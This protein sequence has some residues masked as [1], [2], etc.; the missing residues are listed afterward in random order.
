MQ[1]SSPGTTALPATSSRYAK[2]VSLS[3][4]VRFDI[5]RDVFR[6]RGF[7]FET[8]FLPDSMSGAGALLFLTPAERRYLSQVQGR[9]YANMF[10]LVERFI[11]A[12]MLDVS[13]AHWLGDQTALEA[14]V[15][16]TDEELK[17]QE[18]FR[19]LELLAA[20]GMPDGYR[21]VPEANA[22]ASVVL[23]KSTWAVLALICHIEVFVL[24]HYRQSIAPD[25]ELSPL[26]KDVM[27]HH[28]R[29]ESQHV[30]VDELEWA[31][32]DAALTPQARDAAVDELIEL[33]GAVDGIV[34]A[35]AHADCE[36]FVETCGRELTAG[37]AARVGRTLLDAYRWQYILSG[38]QEPRFTAAL[39]AKVTPAQ[40][41]RIEQALAPIALRARAA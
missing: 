10:G 17:H 2:P 37:E 16:F 5:D 12:K 1:T 40:M 6:G 27:L 33:I 20:D 23:G 32:V 39:A 24:A 34:Q 41:Q 3:K 8:K 21:F 25:A 26:F 4:R 19:R 28:W 29:E 11:G 31:R 15:R 35:Q 36:W 14:L 18:M 38:A 22:V 30:I 7:D 9:T 13:R